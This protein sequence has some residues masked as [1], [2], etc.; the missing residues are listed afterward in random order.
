M[1]SGLFLILLFG[2]I[3]FLC[4]RSGRRQ[5]HNRAKMQL[6]YQ[7]VYEQEAAKK[8]AREARKRGA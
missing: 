1:S 7:D 8:A 6:M 2:G 4:Y 3:V 5:M